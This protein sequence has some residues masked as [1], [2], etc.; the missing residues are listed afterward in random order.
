[1][2]DMNMLVVPGLIALAAFFG[3]KLFFK[4]DDEKEERRRG[5]IKLSSAL[6][7]Y[8]L[9]KIA[10]FM[11][12]YAVGD[13]S[14]MAHRIGDLARLALEGEDPVLKELDTAF[15][16]MI[17]GKLKTDEGRAFVTLALQDAEKKIA[18]AAKKPTV[19]A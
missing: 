1:M 14:G 3:A 18:E 5:A 9:V 15:K 7:N 11:Q 12:D 4:K 13:Y 6:E 17:E 16:R 8:G 19:S 10:G 2:I